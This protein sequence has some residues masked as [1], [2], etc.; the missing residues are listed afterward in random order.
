MDRNCAWNGGNGYIIY[1]KYKKRGEIGVTIATIFFSLSTILGWA[2]YGEVC[3]GY[4][5]I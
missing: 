4:L 2:Y 3:V 5:R 1:L